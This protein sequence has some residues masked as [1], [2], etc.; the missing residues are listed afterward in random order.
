MEIVRGDFANANSKHYVFGTLTVWHTTTQR[1]PYVNM[2]S[3]YSNFQFY[4][5][6]LKIETYAVMISLNFKEGLAFYKSNIKKVSLELFKVT[7]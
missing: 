7:E 4:S 3:P 2:L 1:R 6:V 5:K